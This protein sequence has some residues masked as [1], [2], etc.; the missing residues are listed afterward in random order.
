MEKNLAPLPVLAG[1]EATNPNSALHKALTE[2]QH[3]QKCS[4]LLQQKLNEFE[5]GRDAVRLM[6]FTNGAMIALSLIG[7]YLAIR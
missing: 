4:K 7:W 2:M 3:W 1:A 5:I 6:V